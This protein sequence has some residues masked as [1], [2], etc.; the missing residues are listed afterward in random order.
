MYTDINELRYAVSQLDNMG[1]DVNYVSQQVG[2]IRQLAASLDSSGGSYDD[3]DLMAELEEMEELLDSINNGQGDIKELYMDYMGWFTENQDKITNYLDNWGNFTN[4][5]PSVSFY[6]FITNKVSSTSG[7]Q[8]NQ[9]NGFP[10]YFFNFAN[11]QF[12]SVPVFNQSWGHYNPYLQ[13][14]NSIDKSKFRSLSDLFSFLHFDL[15]YGFSGIGNNLFTNTVDTISF[16]RDFQK[17]FKSYSDFTTNKITEIN[18]IFYNNSPL[19]DFQ[20]DVNPSNIY[21]F[22]TNYYIKVSTD[23]SGSASENKT[24]WFN[25]IEMLLTALVFRPQEVAQSNK[26]DNANASQSQAFGD[27]LKSVLNDDITEVQSKSTDLKE[28]FEKTKTSLLKFFNHLDDKLGS[29]ASKPS[30]IEFFELTVKGEK[31]KVEITTTKS[32]G[33]LADALRS[34]T[35]LCWISFFVYLIYVLS[36]WL[37]HKFSTILKFCYA[38][39]KTL[40]GIG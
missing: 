5:L 37:F 17:D 18:S 40:I 16:H 10:F 21:N 31:K 14:G 9:M 6:Q 11:G 23:P 15:T 30:H 2:L 22:V 7:S 33:S 27:S 8:R 13:D 25:R 29:L 26:F 32:F 12:S 34:I 38:V 39:F 28:Q 1:Q 35:T 20:E 19:E 24:N 3:T 36:I 4:S